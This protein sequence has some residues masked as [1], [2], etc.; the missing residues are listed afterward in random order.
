MRC[1]GIGDTAKLSR[2]FARHLDKTTVAAVGTAACFD[3]AGE[4][5]AP[6]GPG[7]HR[8][9]IT[10]QARIGLNPAGCGNHDVLRVVNTGVEA[11]PAAADT[12]QSATRVAAGGYVCRRKH[13]FAAGDGDRATHT[14]AGTGVYAAGG[15]HMACTL[16]KNANG[17]VDVAALSDTTCRNEGAGG[18]HQSAFGLHGDRTTHVANAF[19]T[20]RTVLRN[21]GSLYQHAAALRAAGTDQRVAFDGKIA[22][23]AAD[24]YRATANQT[25]R[26]R[27]AARP[28]RH[29]AQ[30][31][32]HQLP[33]LVACQALRLDGTRV[34]QGTGKYTDCASA[35]RA[36]IDGLV[37]P[38]LHR[39][40]NIVQVAPGYLNHLPG[41]QHNIAAVAGDDR[42]AIHT[43]IRCHQV[44]IATAR[45]DGTVGPNIARRACACKFELAGAEVCV[46]DV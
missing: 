32:K 42:V 41:S 40:H 43:D 31:L 22:C 12:N 30:R 33:A 20:Q 26:Q 27:A 9:P 28:Q 39:E 21:F 1:A 8:A 44:D 19:C 10:R 45:A 5:V 14:A 17:Q 37:V 2:L 13:Q 25:I 18:L 11:T 24:R 7:H 34:A 15:K 35:Q 36:Q 3:I 6:V 23:A 46:V 38:A 16:R 4:L 29:I